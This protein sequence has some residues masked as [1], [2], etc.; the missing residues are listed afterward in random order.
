MRLTGPS[1]QQVSQAAAWYREGWS[2]PR[3]AGQLEV[4]DE[5]VR[6]KLRAVG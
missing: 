5:T 4:D 1:D 2:L 3:I 6:S